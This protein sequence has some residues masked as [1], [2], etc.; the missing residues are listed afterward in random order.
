ME[1]LQRALVPG[2]WQEPGA[3]RSATDWLLDSLIFTVA[4]LVGALT[5]AH[6]WSHRGVALNVL[7]LAFGSAACVAL[8]ARR[9]R[10]LL[11]VAFASVAAVFALA[12]GA[13]LVAVFNAAVRGWPRTI[14][15]AA[16][17]A[18]V[19]SVTF[20]L[21]NPAAGLVFRQRFPGFMLC[22]IALGW[23][24][25]TRCSGR[26]LPTRPRRRHRL[27]PTLAPSWSSAAPPA[28]AFRSTSTCPTAR[29]CR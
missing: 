11:V 18:V 3:P 4:V 17:V 28:C 24:L 8:W 15:L 27:W 23:G 7:D 14:A 20:P 6:I 13:A 22:A 16:A 1:A 10:P 29:H 12:Q 9:A 2:E 5:L 25:Y 19:G 21:V 26:T